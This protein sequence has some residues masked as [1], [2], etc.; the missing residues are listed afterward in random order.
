MTVAEEAGALEV[1]LST[2]NGGR[3]LAEQLDSLRA[4]TYPHMRLSVRDDGS[5]DCTVELVRSRL[6]DFPGSRLDLGPNVGA[7][8]SFLSLLR[9]VGPAVQFAA[10]CD[11]DDIWAPDKLEVAVGMI[12]DIAG[13]ALYC[14]AVTLVTDGLEAIKTHRRCTRGVSFRNALVENVATGCT[15]VLNRAAIDLVNARQ[16]TALLMHD[17]WCYLVVSAFGTVVYD[18]VP[19]V[20]YRVH[21][22]NAI[23]VAPSALRE[24]KRRASNHRLHGAERTLTAQAQ[25][26]R[27]LYGGRLE[28]EVRAVLDD[29]LTG[30]EP[31]LRRLRYS[32]VGAAYRQRRLDD[33]VFRLL[34]LMKRI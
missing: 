15:I 31:L 19:R 14:S 33:V 32:L 27:R 2:Y 12:R 10:F 23:G 1:L 7:A 6:A 26:F 18:P 20:C 16:P 5:I 30:S 4:Q 25:E 11:Q 8:Q 34:Y 3:H 9:G 21:S 24:W 29:F 17:A 13:P 28:L 22:A